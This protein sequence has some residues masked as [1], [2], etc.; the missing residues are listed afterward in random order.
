MP[1]TGF[2]ISDTRRGAHWHAYVEMDDSNRSLSRFQ[3][4]GRTPD[5][6]LSSPDGVAE[7]IEAR[8]M[9]LGERRRVMAIA[10][11]EWV[12]IGDAR[13]LAHLYAENFVIASRGD[14]IY[15]DVYHSTR[16]IRLYVE[17]LTD[18][19]CRCCEQ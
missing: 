8:I 14:S 17:A 19:E 1:L 3:R 2:E 11:R 7:W 12:E 4:L 16:T 5:A 18:D 15:T 6:T 9:E 10:D 13:D